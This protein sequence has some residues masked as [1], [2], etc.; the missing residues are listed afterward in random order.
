MRPHADIERPIIIDV[1][2]HVAEDT[3]GL[4]EDADLTAEWRRAE[5]VDS[6]RIGP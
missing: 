5:W 6:G 4:I 2:S 3:D 1:E